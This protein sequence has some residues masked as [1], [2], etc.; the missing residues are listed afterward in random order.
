MILNYVDNTCKV[1]NLSFPDEKKPD[2]KAAA[3]VSEIRAKML[4]LQKEY[5]EMLE[6]CASDP[7]AFSSEGACMENAELWLNV[8]A[9][10]YLAEAFFTRDNYC[11]LTFTGQNPDKKLNYYVERFEGIMIHSPA[12]C[13]DAL[14]TRDAFNRYSKK[15]SLTGTHFIV[16]G[17]T[18]YVYSLLP[19]HCHANHCG[20]PMKTDTESVPGTVS[21]NGKLIAIDIGEPSGVQV[22]SSEQAKGLPK[23]Y[24]DKFW[25]KMGSHYYGIAENISGV[26]YQAL[27]ETEKSEWIKCKW[28]KKTE[29]K[30]GETS[31]VEVVEY[32]RSTDAFLEK[33]QEGVQAAYLAAAE[34]TA[35]LCW[36]YGFNPLHKGKKLSF[37][38]E[39]KKYSETDQDAY[40]TVIGHV[41]GYKQ[42]YKASNHGD[43]ENMWAMEGNGYTM[44][45]FR[46]EV[47]R[48]LEL[49]RKKALRPH[50]ILCYL[51]GIWSS[52]NPAAAESA[53]GQDPHPQLGAPLPVLDPD[54]LGRLFDRGLEA[55][56]SGMDPLRFYCETVGQTD[57]AQAKAE[58]E[59]LS[60]AVQERAGVDFST[61]VQSIFSNLMPGAAAAAPTD[62]LMSIDPDELGKFFDRGLE[63]LSFGMDPLRFYCETVGKTDTAQAKAEIERLSAAVQ[64]RAGVD[65]SALVQSIFSNLTPGAAAAAPT[66]PLA[67]I[68][69]DE[70]GK[71]FDR[72][73]EALSS[74]MDP[75]R[76]Y[77][78]TVGQADADQAKA[79]IEQLSAAVEQKA[80][81]DLREIVRKILHL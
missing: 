17:D 64:E 59:Q 22:I 4:A 42:F 77:C 5:R 34:L 61:L 16:D 38:A 12:S 75:L 78:E 3:A 68:D 62:P 30:S 51:T 28:T 47:Q 58:I 14:N 46:R 19:L 65:F 23:E 70:L 60:A 2:P 8:A 10:K 24:R 50:P 7:G 80:G 6:A 49:L 27:S 69:P 13:Q 74:G 35:T 33:T 79:E 40:D 45:S 48:Q 53:P 76:F 11:Y 31:S 39:K 71:F 18:G 44:D 25:K 54:E 66:D 43:P 37:N 73:L 9:G 52:A 32:F 81:V 1:I 55:L 26:A 57:T 41:E 36:L 20:K 21:L 29:N 15:G 67:S 56:S 72:G 63:A